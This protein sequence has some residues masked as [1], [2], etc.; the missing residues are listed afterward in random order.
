MEFCSVLEVAEEGANAEKQI[1]ADPAMDKSEAEEESYKKKEVEKGGTIMPAQ[2]NDQEMMIEEQEV[3]S[4]TEE[5]I[6]ASLTEMT[7]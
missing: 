1:Q 3:T 6:S 5:K 2:V 4:Q 7:H